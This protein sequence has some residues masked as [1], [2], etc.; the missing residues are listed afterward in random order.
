MVALVTNSSLNTISVVQSLEKRR[1]EL[2]MSMAALAQRAGI[3]LR[4]VQRVLAGEADAANLRTIAAIA[5]ALDAD[6]LL[7]PRTTVRAVRLRAARRKAK[8]LAALVQGTSAL[9]DQAADPETI[10]EIEDRITHGLL[11]GSPRRLWND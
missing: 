11:A 8:R 7:Q 10:R 5:D 4:T 2:G 3:S 6:L 1:Q 9:E